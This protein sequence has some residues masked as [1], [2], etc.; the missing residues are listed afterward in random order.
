MCQK[1]YLNHELMRKSMRYL[2]P[3]K[4]KMQSIAHLQADKIAEINLLM[5]TE[6]G[7]LAISIG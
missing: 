1:L 6:L 5:Y 2:Q 4:N 3:L 7:K